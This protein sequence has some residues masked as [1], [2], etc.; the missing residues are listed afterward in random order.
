MSRTHTETAMADKHAEAY[1][2]TAMADKM[3]ETSMPMNG[4]IGDIPDDDLKMEILEIEK[5]LDLYVPFNMEGMPV[6]TN[7]LTIRAVV[8]GICLGALVNASNLYL[9]KLPTK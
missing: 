7:I 9:G 2:E 4:P 6:E 1:G 3:T 5:D 8:V